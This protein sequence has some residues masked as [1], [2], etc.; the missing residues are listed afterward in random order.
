M[1][2]AATTDAP[3]P[4]PKKY[5]LL[6]GIDQYE[7]GD[8]K[9][10]EGAKNDVRLVREILMDRFEIPE[11]NIT[12]LTDDAASH[13]GIRDAFRTL[14]E[15]LR[16]GDMVYIH[17]SGHGSYTCDINGDEDP[18]WGRDSTWVAYGTRS[19]EG[20]AGADCAAVRESKGDDDAGASTRSVAPGRLNDFDILDDEING[21]LA[22]LTAK[23]DEV[24]FVSDSCHSGTVT[25]G[26]EALATRG[27]PIDMRAH[28]LG[29]MPPAA[30]LTGGLRVSACRDSE[31]AN[32]YKGE[33]GIHG[34]FTWFWCQSLQEAQPGDTWND[35]HRRAMAKVLER[36]TNQHPQI[37]GDRH[38]VVF[39][40]HFQDRPKTATIIY[41]SHDGKEARIDEGSLL[42]VTAGSIYRKYDPEGDA[43]ESSKLSITETDAT[44]SNGAVQGTFQVG[45]RVTLEH[46]RH[47]TAPMKVMVRADLEKDA[48]L[49][50]RIAT[51]VGELPTY[52]ITD[53]Q[54]ESDFVLYIVRPQQE[55]GDYVY[56]RDNDS[57]PRSFPDQPP[58]CWIMT[59]EEQLYHEDLI[60][61][62]TDA[63]QGART[64][65]HNLEKIAR[66]RNLTTLT[67]AP[68]RKS[69]VV[70]NVTIWEEAP[71]GA[72]GEIKVE[73][74]QW[75]KKTAV[76]AEGLAEYDLEVGQLLTFSIQNVSDQSYFTYLIDI[77]SDGEI[78]PFYPAPF[79][80]KEHGKIAPGGVRNVEAVTLYMDEPCREYI[81][82]IASMK[83]IDIYALEQKRYRKDQDRA[84]RS[85]MSALDLLLRSKAGLTRS[86]LTGPIATA[87][88]TTVQGAFQVTE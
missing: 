48:P 62:M 14:A 49:V 82:L 31:K 70:L 15:T 29:N 74:K 10:L 3:K 64:I 53:D 73:G 72:A 22:S 9:P 42:G 51:A 19:G 68:G 75:R 54:K 7:G 81:R 20:S 71:P 79:Q 8:F 34:L 58:Q 6:I 1:A 41:V 5:A 60:I 56:A 38:Q 17:Y 32:E 40:G 36:R 37:E 63:R 46:Y 11:D 12:L 87:E 52:T 28:P 26:E 83:P 2:I 55:D 4:T 35:I 67:S 88:W 23:T 65:R 77:T 25:R 24:I 21:W 84:Q 78:I 39:G 66:V 43:A 18:A 57:L 59:P 44:E 69:P 61:G 30:P 33:D 45:D 47:D 86:R 85:G 50:E 13:T 76:T 27:V 80:S 16:S